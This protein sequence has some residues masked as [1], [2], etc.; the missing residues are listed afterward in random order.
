MM[1]SMLKKY[2]FLIWFFAILQL[3]ACSTFDKTNIKPGE[4]VRGFGFSFAVPTDRHWFATEYG[5]SNRLKLIQLNQED[6]YSILVTLNKGPRWGMYPSADAHLSVV[7]YHKQHE[8]QPRGYF[9]LAHQ[10]WVD[11]SYGDLCVRY[12]VHA[13]DWRGRNKQGAALIDTLGLSCEHGSLDNV[14]ITIE[15]SHRYE[16][17]GEKT[18]IERYARRLFKS[19]KFEPVPG[20]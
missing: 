7:Q 8:I 16:E 6:S 1:S 14:L 18:D 19:L 10:E 2:R 13:K 12:S 11:E 17:S 15:F 4:R 20:S 5:T 3:S 9:L